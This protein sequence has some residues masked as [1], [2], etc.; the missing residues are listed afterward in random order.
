MT[1]RS[2]IFTGLKSVNKTNIVPKSIDPDSI[3]NWTNSVPCHIEYKNFKENRLPTEDEVEAMKIFFK[4]EMAR[5]EVA[6]YAA[7]LDEVQHKIKPLF[8]EFIKQKQNAQSIVANEI[9]EEVKIQI[10]D[11]IAERKRNMFE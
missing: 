8:D 4:L 9:I 2:C 3:D 6:F 7:K 1:V 11:V 5:T 10:K